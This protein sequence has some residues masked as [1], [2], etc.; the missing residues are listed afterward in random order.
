LENKEN[1]KKK[2]D[3]D[4]HKVFHEDLDEDIFK[5]KYKYYPWA[6]QELEEAK[7]FRKDFPKINFYD[8]N[9]VN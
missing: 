2:V 5:E 8:A 3:S 9:I 6:L 4:L 1:L 7:D